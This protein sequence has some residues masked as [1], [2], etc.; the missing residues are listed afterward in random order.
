MKNQEVR[1]QMNELFE[2]SI[3]FVEKSEK[4]VPENEK[5][6]VIKELIQ[7][8]EWYDKKEVFALFSGEIKTGKSS[9]INNI[10][11]EDICTVDSGVCTNTNTVIKWGKEEVI[12]VY[13]S[14]NKDEQEEPALQIIAREEIKLFV[15]E[16]ENSNNKKNVR[17]IEVEIPNKHL[18]N[19]LILIDTPGL[20]SL[21]PLHTATTFSMAPIADIIFLVSSASREL[22]KPEI[23]YFQRLLDCSK[24]QAVIH[25]L[26]N[27]DIGNP[28]IILK[29][30]IEHLLKIK[31]WK[32]GELKW[33]KVSNINYKKFLSG[34]LNNITGSGFDVFNSLLEEVENNTE[35]I[36]TKRQLDIVCVILLRLEN[37]LNI[38]LKAMNEPKEANKLKNE[39]QDAKDRLEQL[40][41]EDSIW[42][43]NLNSAVEKLNEDIETRINNEYREIKKNVSKK[44]HLDEYIKNPKKLG[45]IVTSEIISQ[46]SKLQDHLTNKFADIY[47]LILDESGLNLIYQKIYNLTEPTVSV[48]V[49][50]N[51]IKIDKL[52]I[53][54]RAIKSRMFVYGAVGSAIGA[55][56]GGIVGTLIVPGAGTLAGAAIGA[57]IVAGIASA[58][59]G[60]KSIIIGKEKVKDEKRK[61]IMDIITPQVDSANRDYLSQIRR[62]TLDSEKKLR[63]E[64]EKE[65]SNEIKKYNKIIMDIQKGIDGDNQ[66]HDEIILLKE[67]LNE[68]LKF[69]DNIYF[70]INPK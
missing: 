3:R 58:W 32:Q 59:G 61:K 13:F 10:L 38:S 33:C 50:P 22:T 49:N 62:I 47:Q 67:E 28:D 6:G 56:V 41:S 55:V 21:N 54:G 69:M 37:H 16:K 44:L 5:S 48:N 42:R 46:S 63:I 66:K 30:N 51:D 53:Y 27:A 12:R 17:L 24:C 14:K 70:F 20:G 9:L 23:D 36:L 19:G 57:N 68:I 4:D 35:I 15:S 40:Q 29:N 45:S 65:L 26:T 64:F 60:V 39:I 18:E 25:T 31:E 34:K 2:K 8:K 43:I 52:Q 7:A 11:E 1:T